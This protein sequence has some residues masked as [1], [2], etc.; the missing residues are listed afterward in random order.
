MGDTTF[1][2]STLERALKDGSLDRSSAS[3]TGM[4]KTADAKGTIL[5]SQAGCEAWVEIP[6]DLVERAER[7]GTEVCRD[8]THPVFTLTLTEPQDPTAKVLVALFKASPASPI[9]AGAPAPPQAVP[10]QYWSAHGQ[11]PVTASP[12]SV[13]R[14]AFRAQFY[15]PWQG[16]YPPVGF[17]GDMWGG[18]GWDSTLPSCGYEEVVCGS[19]P[20]GVPPPTCW[21]YCCRWP[22]G[23]HNCRVA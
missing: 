6:T 12:P 5:F 3:L 20:P 10:P 11:N 9:P 23:H 17:P 22:N 21:I 15:P 16:A 7:A 1:T 4:V 19:S 8:H 14:T 2:G 13:P 18:W